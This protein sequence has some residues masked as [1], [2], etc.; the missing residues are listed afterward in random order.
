MSLAME[1]WK[2]GDIVMFISKKGRRKGQR[3]TLVGELIEAT[4]KWSVRWTSDGAVKEYAVKNLKKIDPAATASA[5]SAVPAWKQK[6]IIEKEN[7]QLKDLLDKQATFLPSAVEEIKRTRRLTKRVTWWFV[8][9]SA[10]HKH[11]VRTSSCFE[12]CAL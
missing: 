10:C 3:G 9:A 11:S 8:C 7:K 4:K 2:T 5:A 12:D 6:Q 1:N